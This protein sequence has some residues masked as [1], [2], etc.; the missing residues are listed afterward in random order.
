MKTLQKYLSPPILIIL[1]VLAAAGYFILRK[2][3]PTPIIPTTPPVT[4]EKYITPPEPIEL[5]FIQEDVD[6]FKG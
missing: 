6:G 4:R 1:V 2:P 3:E 5:P